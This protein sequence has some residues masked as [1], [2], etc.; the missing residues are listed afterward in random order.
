LLERRGVRTARFLP[1]RIWPP[2][3]S[4][5]LRNHRKI[6]VVDGCMA[7]A[8]GINIRDGYLV[9]NSPHSHRI[10]DL[11]AR[12]AGPIAAQIE[13]VFVHDWQVV[14]GETALPP[15]LPIAPAGDAVCRAVVDGP[16]IE[17]DRLTELLVGAIAN[18]KQR[19]AIM[20][21]YFLPPR[22]LIAPLQAAAL[23][24]IDVAVILPEHNNL[25]YV[26]RATR[27]MLW[28]LLQRD[29]RI[30]YQPPPF[31]HSKLFYIDDDYAQLGSANLD[32]RSLRL[33]FEM[34]VEIYDRALVARLSAHFETV[35]ARS[36]QISLHEVDGRPFGTKLLDGV[37]W[38]F[39]PYL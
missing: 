39:T 38:L 31:V 37:A 32:P 16:E 2:Q 27:H 17:F 5:N 30:Y 3:F 15:P 29:V 18:A 23:Q 12:F 14:T 34:N 22:E 11:H 10:A 8:G 19:V 28:E 13:N 33:N 20:T 24:G 36:Q 9:P 6:L 35:R 21:P 7:F 26:H 4:V 25:P 1:P